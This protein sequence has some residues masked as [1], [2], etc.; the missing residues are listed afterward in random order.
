MAWALASQVAAVLV[1]AVSS[2]K[3]HR[4]CAVLFWFAP[5]TAV[6]ATG[7]RVV[8][9]SVRVRTCGAGAMVPSSTPNDVAGLRVSSVAVT[10][11]ACQVASPPPHETLQD[12]TA[13]SATGSASTN[14]ALNSSTFAGIVAVT[15][16]V[17]ACPGTIV[18]VDAVF[19]SVGR[20]TSTSRDASAV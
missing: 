15:V 5:C 16:Q 13:L 17:T 1:G 18:A 7:S 12:S 20:T 10:Q 19:D 4:S 2:S 9:V 14:A 3:F 11:S 8:R 6:V